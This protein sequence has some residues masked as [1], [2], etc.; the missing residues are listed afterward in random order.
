LCA[1][2]APTFGAA[3]DW[4]LQVPQLVENYRNGSAEAISLGFIFIWFL[5]D[6]FNLIGAA[7]AG[8]VPVIIAIAI[9]FCLADGVLI[10][11]CLYYNII[12]KRKGARAVVAEGEASDEQ[13]LLARTRSGS[14]TIPGSRRRSSTASLRRRSSGQ[15]S[16]DVLSKIMEEDENSGRL[17]LR[18][19][20]SV[21]AI[22]AAGTAGWALAWQSGAWKPTP[23]HQDRAEEEIAVGA[24]VLGY[25]SAVAYLGA[26]IPQI[27]KNWRE[28]SCE[29]RNYCPSSEDAN[30][31]RTITTVLHSVVDGQCYVW[32]WHIVSF[33]REAILHDESSVAD[34]QSWYHGGGCYYICAVSHLLEPRRGKR[35]GGMS[36]HVA[37]EGLY[38]WKD[39]PANKRY[40]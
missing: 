32:S 35:R 36:L 37:L 8:L 11:Q 21:L 9:Y 22:I 14:L 23:H 7:W 19:T 34:R 33:D 17:W 39:F 31:C 40:L 6:V 27:L 24:Q 25:A 15:P 26:R 16:T 4:L 20:V 2:P 29:G 12:N 10:S 18:N 30:E 3:I 1:L 5:G 28:K 13:P 38:V